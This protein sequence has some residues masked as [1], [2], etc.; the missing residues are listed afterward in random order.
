MERLVNEDDLLFAN[1][2]NA[3]GTGEI[4]L[5]RDE[6]GCL[7]GRSG[8]DDTAG[9]FLSDAA[10]CF[11]GVFFFLSYPDAILLLCN[12]VGL[13]EKIKKIKIHLD[14][15]SHISE[16]LLQAAW[17]LLDNS[18][19]SPSFLDDVYKIFF[20]KPGSEAQLSSA[21]RATAN[22]PSFEDSISRICEGSEICAAF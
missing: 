16:P 22:Q 21:H 17:R 18:A 10:C 5:N 8:Q 2:G 20:L 15:Y 11:V 12:N 3:F 1:S 19:P 13:E 4:I 9:G 7:A 6:K 14:Y